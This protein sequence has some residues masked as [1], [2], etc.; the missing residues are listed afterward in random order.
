[1]ILESKLRELLEYT[2]VSNF[3]ATFSSFAKEESYDKTFPFQFKRYWLYSI[4]YLEKF[5]KTQPKAGASPN[6][7]NE[8][9]MLRFF[10][11]KSLT[12]GVQALRENKKCTSEKIPLERLS[13]VCGIVAES[14]E[15]LANRSRYDSYKKLKLN[16]AKK[17]Y[18]ESFRL[19]NIAK[20]NHGKLG[21]VCAKLSN[22][23]I[24]PLEKFENLLEEIVSCEA[25]RECGNQ[26]IENDCSIANTYQ[27]AGHL[28]AQL[29]LHLDE[30]EANSLINVINDSRNCWAYGPLKDLVVLAADL[31]LSRMS[32]RGAA[33]SLLEHALDEYNKIHDYRRN[34]NQPF[35]I[36]DYSYRGKC[37]LRL[38]KLKPNREFI[39]NAITDLEKA[40][41]LEDKSPAIFSLLGEAYFVLAHN[42][43]HYPAAEEK[44][45]YF[46]ESLKY[47]KMSEQRNNSKPEHYGMFAEVYRH[48]LKLEFA[49]SNCNPELLSKYLNES[50]RYA[51]KAEVARK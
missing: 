11:L 46:F 28:T 49:K 26:D 18:K 36:E 48:L 40:V 10:L 2:D 6:D 30:S 22:L 41:S 50:V 20:E 4:W 14:C 31:K 44:E 34:N 25:S 42:Y 8:K 37:L 27:E 35:C 9:R 15:Q 12:S 47:L 17:F 43:V 13:G 29:D 38:S 33:I 24:K 39:D 23:S 3:K 16:K 7:K 19:G 45:R 32:V 21:R 1:M 5:K 51:E